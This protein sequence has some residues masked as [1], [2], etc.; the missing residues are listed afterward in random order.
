MII[1]EIVECSS[2]VTKGLMQI[3]KKKMKPMLKKIIS[4]NLFA[5]K[6]IPF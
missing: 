3:E 6:T 4:A 2:I 5:G 1:T